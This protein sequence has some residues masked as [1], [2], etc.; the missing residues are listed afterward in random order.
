MA[1]FDSFVGWRLVGALSVTPSHCIVA[2]ISPS[3]PNDLPVSSVQI[4]HRSTAY[5]QLPLLCQASLTHFRS[6]SCTGCCSY[7]PR[8][9]KGLLPKDNDNHTCR[10][11]LRRLRPRGSVL[12]WGCQRVRQKQWSCIRFAVQICAIVPRY[13][14][15]DYRD[16]GKEDASAVA[17]TSTCGTGAYGGT[18]AR[19]TNR[20]GHGA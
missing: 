3:Y 11:H 20:D 12:E 7:H 1:A 15:P 4:H 18:R 8:R 19:N 17:D 14:P 10:C 16:R 13:S 9:L 2:T 5:F 6:R